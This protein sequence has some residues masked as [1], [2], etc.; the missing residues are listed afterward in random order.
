MVRVNSKMTLATKKYDKIPEIVK[1][2]RDL[3]S[4]INHLNPYK[5]GG[6]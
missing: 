6:A 4:D 1:K 3:S 2:Y 5:T